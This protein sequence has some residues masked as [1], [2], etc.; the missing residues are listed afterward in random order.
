MKIMSADSRKTYWQIHLL[1]EYALPETSAC[2]DL[3]A[4]SGTIIASN[5]IMILLYGEIM[6]FKHIRTHRRI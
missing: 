4:H 6:K 3:S 2:S 5:I 1:A